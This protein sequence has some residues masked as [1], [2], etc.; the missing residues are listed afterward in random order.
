M[1]RRAVARIIAG[2]LEG[3][4]LNYRVLDI[5][6]ISYTSHHRYRA[7]QI[8]QEIMY[9]SRVLVRIVLDGTSV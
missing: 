5:E 3:L 7:H 9:R 2:V 4:G 8:Y 6:C 1:S